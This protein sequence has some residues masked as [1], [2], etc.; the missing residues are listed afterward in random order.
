MTGKVRK[1]LK[2]KQKGRLGLGGMLLPACTVVGELNFY[3]IYF[4]FLNSG[5]RASIG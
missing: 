5:G 4:F 3:F 2:T 1:L